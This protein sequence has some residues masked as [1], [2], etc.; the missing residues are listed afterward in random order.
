MRFWPIDF[1]AVHHLTETILN[2]AQLAFD[3]AVSQAVTGVLQWFGTALAVIGIPLTYRQSWKAAVAAK[4]AA[5]AVT[6]FQYRLGSVNVAH[7]YSQLELAKG[8]VLS[9]DY[10][11]AI[12]VV[13]ILKR[14]VLHTISFFEKAASPPLNLSV[15]RRNISA[16]EVQLAK[17]SRSDSTFKTRTLDRAIS[18]LSDCLVDW[19]NRFVTNAGQ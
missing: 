5:R 15:A 13:G 19:E 4:E 8:F 17:A 16:I 6:Q 9:K 3:W 7:A 18:G 1:W 2:A 10:T 11:A 14:D 12:T